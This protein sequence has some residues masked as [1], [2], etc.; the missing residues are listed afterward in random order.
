M[1]FPDI[2]FEDEVRD[3]FY[4][5]AVAKHV[6]AAQMR[7]VEKFAQICKDHDLKWFADCGTVLGAIRHK[8]FIPWDDDVDLVMPREDYMKFVSLP[9][10]EL[11]DNFIIKSLQTSEIW[12]EYQ[13]QIANT[14]QIPLKG[15]AL[16]EY[17]D[18]PLAVYIDIFVL[19]YVHP[20]EEEEKKIKDLTYK[21][22][23]L[24]DMVT[25]D[26]RFNIDKRVWFEDE[27]LFIK[28][29]SKICGEEINIDSTLRRH[30]YNIGEW[31]NMRALPEKDRATQ[32]CRKK[33]GI[34]CDANYPKE[35]WDESVSVDFECMKLPVPA[36]YTRYLE[37]A[38]GKDYIKPKR[39]KMGDHSWPYY[40]NQLIMMRNAGA[41]HIKYLPEIKER[42]EGDQNFKQRLRKILH[43]LPEVH[44]EIDK[45][46]NEGKKREAADLL[47]DCQ[48]L[49]VEADRIIEEEFTPND[50]NILSDALSRIND[51]LNEYCEHLYSIYQTITEED[52]G[53]P[54]IE[55]EKED[56]TVKMIEGLLKPSIKQDIVI[57]PFRYNSWEALSPV[58]EAIKES[59]E[60][61]VHIV[62]IP[63]YL[64]KTDGTLY[65]MK[66]DP[67]KYPQ[68]IEISDYKQFDLKKMHPDV[69]IIQEP[70]DECNFSTSIHPD[71]YSSKLKDYTERLIYIPWFITDD[72]TPDDELSFKSMDWYACTPGVCNSDKVIVQSS[73]MK[74]NYINKLC[75]VTGQET[76][77]Y[78][79]KK[80][81]G[82]GSPLENDSADYWGRQ[83][84][85]ILTE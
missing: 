31:L 66:Y 12:R 43:L 33:W 30:L 16:E 25:E 52:A 55:T 15:D 46:C 13:A 83:L 1:V 21:T 84:E 71:F 18:C 47:A 72:F 4:V 64:K 26:G 7:L 67:D 76:K 57:L 24:A 53:T 3:G 8:G 81:I 82:A 65:N 11:P 85:D 5:S 74:N 63:Y 68:D 39:L 28:K 17:Y 54:V 36:D 38:Y 61:N 45:L 73:N 80:I 22:M 2:Y 37:L 29:L 79:E 77:E 62:P 27:K 60:Y 40:D 78:W 34:F 44:R 75:A 41:R 51:L 10:E 58:Y 35:L 69:I 59:G 48:D 42:E 19:D 49:A 20:D 32:V 6:W 9:K 14:V 23:L 70:Q 56:D 50:R